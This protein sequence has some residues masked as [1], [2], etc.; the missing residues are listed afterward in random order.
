MKKTLLVLILL[1]ILFATGFFFYLNREI[2]NTPSPGN[3]TPEEREE[4]VDLISKATS[5]KLNL[6]KKEEVREAIVQPVTEEKK[7]TPEQKQNILN[8][9][10]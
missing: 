2:Q 6:E 9:L 1:I 7:L 3:L 5:T 4:V 8:S 10:K